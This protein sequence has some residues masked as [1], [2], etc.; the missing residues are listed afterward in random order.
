MA[1]YFSRRIKLPSNQRYPE[2]FE[3]LAIQGINCDY[4]WEKS[5]EQYVGVYEHIRHK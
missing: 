2:L 1:S 5:G 4:S 3:K